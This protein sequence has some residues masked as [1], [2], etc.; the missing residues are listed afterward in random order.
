MH[1]RIFMLDNARQIIDIVRQMAGP[2]LHRSE[3]AARQEK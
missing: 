2:Y 1:F 3:S